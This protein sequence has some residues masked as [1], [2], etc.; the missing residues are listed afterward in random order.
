MFILTNIAIVL[1]ITTAL[2]VAGTFVAWGRR[3]SQ[4][5]LYFALGM[6][7]LTFWTLA[8]GLGYAAVP[9]E[10]KIL[11]A[12]FDAIGYHSALVLLLICTMYFAGLGEWVEG[13]WL[14]VILFL[15]PGLSIL[16]ISTNELHGWVWKRFTPAGNNV[17]VFEH[18]PGF[19]LVAIT[20]Y[21]LLICMVGILFM[22]SRKGSD[23]QK[24]QARL[25]LFASVFTLAANMVYLYGV[26]G[27]EGVDWSSV[28]FSSTGL[29]VLLALRF[30]RFTDIIPIARDHLVI[31]LGDGM[32]VVDA[33]KRIIDMNPA[34]EKIFSRRSSSL[35]GTSLK[36][37][38][39]PDLYAL[40]ESSAGQEVRAEVEFGEENKRYSEVLISPIQNPKQNAALGRLIL[41]RDIT[42]RH[43]L[44]TERE[45]LIHDL[46]R[47]IDER[48]LVEKE[49]EQSQ[50][51]LLE[52]QRTLAATQ[53][54]QRLG[55]N[56]HDSVNQS[57]HSLM[58]FS[59]TLIALLQ[60]G[61][62][63]QALHAA[64]R[65][66]ESGE[67]ALKEVRM[68]V[69]E[70]QESFMGGYDELI[71]AIEKRMN[72]VERRVGIQAD[73]SYDPSVLE[74]S[75]KEWMENIYWII[76]EGL[77]NS[78]KHSQANRVRVSIV[79]HTN[80]IIVEIK[81]NGT[82]FD[83]GAVGGGGF[84]M[85]SIH[86]RAEILGGELSV[87]SSPGQGTR[88]KCTLEIPRDEPYQNSNRG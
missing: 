74:R 59:E 55:R 39:P 4:T 30:A 9:L 86:Q 50:A 36:E 70:G 51:Q 46:A 64:E 18:G 88:V 45:K 16:L 80:Q 84:G 19:T 68:L 76:M 85:R 27:A 49:L 41:F 67:Q 54:R 61:E 35:V 12:K 42:R 21:L 37:I 28:T 26:K 71:L 17:V 10:L 65:I 53:E 14:R 23:I 87:E 82:G 2:N 7:G 73:F 56:L 52:H 57:I 43:R 58:L 44:E 33:E 72:M 25:L 79:D 66:Y 81:D 8:A 20:G 78:L 47:E 1:F 15:L 63:E 77:N 69:H 38:V 34:A 6:M 62:V 40:M 24:Q 75:P 32:V 60:N 3:K 5:G 29:I 22:V 83:P 48:K 31:S 13:K 11:F